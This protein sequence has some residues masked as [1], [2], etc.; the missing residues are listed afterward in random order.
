MLHR[1]QARARCEHPT[2]EDALD[3]A[4]QR[5]LVNLDEGIGVRSLRRRARVADAWRHLERA[6]LHGLADGCIEGD[7][8]AGDFVEAGEHRTLVGNLLR[9]RLGDTL[10]TGRWR[11]VGGLGSAARLTFAGR[12]RRIDGR[13]GAFGRGERLRLH[14]RG[15][16]FAGLPWIGLIGIRLLRIAR[17]RVALVRIGWIALLL[18]ARLAAGH[19][20]WWPR[21]RP[22]QGLQRVEE[23]RARGNGAEHG[24]SRDRRGDKAGDTKPAGHGAPLLVEDGRKPRRLTPRIRRREGR[25][26]SAL[27]P[28]PARPA[29]LSNLCCPTSDSGLSDPASRPCSRRSPWAGGLVPGLSRSAVARR[30]CR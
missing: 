15:R 3:L 1:V 17:P 14:T 13:R 7:D 25:L 6:E 20:R 12:K 11:D 27:E 30:G 18:G 2:S 29:L 16:A 24:P 21:R 4:L 9:W 26:G 5:H 23:L 22:K 28:L 19:A 8:A 10:V